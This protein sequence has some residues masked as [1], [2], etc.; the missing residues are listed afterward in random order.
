MRLHEAVNPH[1]AGTAQAQGTGHIRAA[2]VD[3]GHA[4]GTRDPKT[5]ALLAQPG[6]AGQC[7]TAGGQQVGVVGHGRRRGARIGAHTEPYAVGGG[8]VQAG[9]ALTDH[10]GLC[11]AA[12]AVYA[13]AGMHRAHEECVAHIQ[14]DVRLQAPGQQQRAGMHTQVIGR[15]VQTVDDLDARA[16]LVGRACADGVAKVS[17]GRLNAQRGGGQQVVVELGHA[18]GL[19]AHVLGGGEVAA[20]QGVALGDHLHL[21]AGQ[22]AI[23]QPVVADAVDRTVEQDVESLER[24]GSCCLNSSAAAVK[25]EQAQLGLN[26]DRYA[27]LGCDDGAV[28]QHIVGAHQGQAAAGV[29]GQNAGAVLDDQAVEAGQHTLL[30]GGGVGDGQRAA[31]DALAVTAAQ[32][33][34][35]CRLDGAE[36]GERAGRAQ[37]H[38]AAGAACNHAA[39]DHTFVAGGEADRSVDRLQD[40]GVVQVDQTAVE[41]DGA[42]GAQLACDVLQAVVAPLNA[43]VDDRAGSGGVDRVPS[44]RAVGGGAIGEAQ[45]EIGRA[46][47]EAGSA[48][49][50]GGQHLE[51]IGANQAQLAFTELDGD[52]GLACR[53]IGH[54][55]QAGIDRVQRRQ[56]AA[57]RVGD[58]PCGCQQLG[59]ERGLQ[60]GDS[61]IARG[62]CGSDLDDGLNLVAN[63]VDLGD[64][65]DIA[66]Q[67]PIG[68]HWPVR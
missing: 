34:P 15:Q 44:D 38:V 20:Q 3:H 10:R 11:A 23:G 17:R 62:A 48:M 64:Q 6:A 42:V 35:V 21:V 8:D 4:A 58:P 66:A 52:V 25:V 47:G 7:Q 43:N 33:H 2:I 46:A 27:A 22:A 28:D 1:V 67:A 49:H 30:P 45:A 37:H 60:L 68:R 57:L 63:L 9:I 53:E 40:A 39:L 56:G 26:F 32:F 24:E 36:N 5:Q 16:L 65:P 54:R 55:R 41:I 13:R 19:D 61:G 12:A 31:A 14:G 50:G 18:T 29:R 51:L 59:I